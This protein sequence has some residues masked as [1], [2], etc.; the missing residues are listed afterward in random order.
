MAVANSRLASLPDAGALLDFLMEDERPTFIL[1]LRD[2]HANPEIVF[3]NASLDTLITQAK[4]PLAFENWVAMASDSLLNG[5][6]FYCGRQW[7]SK[8]LR[9][10]WR[11]VSCDAIPA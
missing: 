3:K 9:E 1:E 5:F 6:E 11:I 8:R 7:S 2:E 4:E 10:T